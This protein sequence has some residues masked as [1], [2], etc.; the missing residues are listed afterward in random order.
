MHESIA[1]HSDGSEFKF[2]YLVSGLGK[3][4][5]SKIRFLVSIVSDP[6]GNGSINS[7]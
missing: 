7:G 2:I 4:N 6:I 5:F 1:L 3:F